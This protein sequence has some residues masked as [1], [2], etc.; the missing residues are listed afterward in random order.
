ML[1]SKIWPSLVILKRVDGV[2]IS[3]F[4]VPF[5][6]LVIQGQRDDDHRP[7]DGPTLQ[8]MKCSL[9]LLWPL[10]I[11][12]VATLP[13]QSPPKT[14]RRAFG[15]F[16]L[17]ITAAG[18][19]TSSP[20]SAQLPSGVSSG[21]PLMP[22]G[23]ARYHPEVVGEWQT[24][25]LRTN[26]GQ[27]RVAADE[28]YPLQQLPFSGD[29][30]LYYAP[31]LFGAWNATATL[32]RKVYPYGT[33]YLPSSSLLEGSPRN[34]EE[35]VG[36]VCTY[37]V[38]YFS[39]I[40]KTLANQLT[41]NLGTGVP[42]TKVIQDRSFNAKSISRAYNQLT[43]VQEVDW[44]YSDNPTKLVLD[45]GAGPVAADMRPL[46]PRR[47][48]IFLNARATEEGGEGDVYA[49][50]ERSRSVTLGP[51]TAI[52]SD[53]ETITEFHKVSD[54]HVGA[55]S[56]IAVYLSPNPNSREGVMWQQVGGKAVAFFD[57][58]IEMER[59]KEDFRL[60]DGLVVRRACVLTPKEVV[61][62]Y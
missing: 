12:S 8:S 35:A 9:P 38:H 4:Q 14:S 16:L 7:V 50:A 47:A 27:N 20:S 46:G 5:V 30:E 6:Q 26:L 15:G 52:V 43:P 28:L 25:N 61:Q 3:R 10:F 57:Y 39:T 55:V 45:F 34:R 60:D 24:A 13:L 62:C 2:V 22:G 54:D 33:D 58:E 1:S 49:T 18:V 56:R 29:Q 44:N 36:N 17:S 37:E 51:G 23:Y 31:F 11:G 42:A 48:E 32:R 40:A 19:A 59:I 41:V 53:T 21:A